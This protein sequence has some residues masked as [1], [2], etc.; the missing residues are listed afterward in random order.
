MSTSLSASEMAELA[1][2]NDA[3]SGLMKKSGRGGKGSRGGRGGG[4]GGGGQNREVVISKALS[5]LLRHAAEDEGLKLDGEGFARLDLVVS[6]S[7]SVS[8]V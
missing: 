6:F 1:E 5:K 4:G 2:A 7:F 8:C 3:D